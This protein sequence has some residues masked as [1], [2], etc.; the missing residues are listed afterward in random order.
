MH[1]SLTQRVLRSASCLALAALCACQSSEKSEA[2]VVR[3]NGRALEATYEAPS[4]DHDVEESLAQFIRGTSVVDGCQRVQLDLQNR[5]SSSVAF[6]YQVEWLDR[7]G[8]VVMDREALWTPL[9]L[10]G[11]E[12]VPLE[13]KAPHPRAESWRLR[14]VALPP[15]E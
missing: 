11:G 9:V 1:Q 14:A 8:E 3:H 10:R 6:A 4:E 12:Q 13:L 2:N 7:Q 15:A 5:S